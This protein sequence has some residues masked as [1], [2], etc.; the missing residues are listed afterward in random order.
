VEFFVYGRDRPGTA[1]LRDRT[2]EAHW[3]FMDDYDEAMIARGPTLTPD[4]TAATGSMHIVDLPDLEAARAFAFDEPYYRAGVFGEVIVRRWRSELG[5][6][7]WDFE[8]DEVNNRRFLLIAHAKPG[9]GPDR[10]R[11]DEEYRRY[12]AEQDRLGH[13]IACGPLLSDDGAFW[14]GTATL[15]EVPDRDAVGTVLA[16]EPCAQAGLYEEVEAHDWEFGGRR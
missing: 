11:V 9:T 13:L 12:I 4:R 15:I 1:E 2:T 5:R 7:M 16:A 14:V 8:G 10:E 3:S 6:T